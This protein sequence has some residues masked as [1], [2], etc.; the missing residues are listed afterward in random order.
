MESSLNIREAV[1]LL[2]LKGLEERNLTPVRD[3]QFHE[4]VRR[5]QP[6][7]DTA[8]RF[9]DEPF[10]FSFDLQRFLNSLKWHSHVNELTFAGNGWIPRP[11]YQL[12]FLGRTR[13]KERFAELE[14]SDS[15]LVSRI[16]DE[17]DI[18]AANHT[19]PIESRA[20]LFESRLHG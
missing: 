9:I 1:V 13:A 10:S 17:L 6:Q 16:N 19:P 2:V 3:C 14:A 11:E 4:L 12:S 15:G 20:E 5:V 7:D 8:F 18:F